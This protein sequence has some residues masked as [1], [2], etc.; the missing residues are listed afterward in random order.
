MSTPFT[1]QK[2]IEENISSIFNNK[3][4]IAAVAE[5]SFNNYKSKYREKETNQ[6]NLH[7]F[8]VGHTF[9]NIDTK[10]IFDYQLNEDESDTIPTKYLSLQQSHFQFGIKSILKKDKNGNEK[11]EK[12]ENL[13]DLMN[14]IRNIN[15]HYIHD[16]AFL[17]INQIDEKIIQFLKE[18]FEVALIQ[19]L[20]AKK[21]D[22][23]KNKLKKDFLSNE[24]KDN[25]LS[26]IIDDKDKELITFM[27][28]IF[29]QTLYRK[30]EKDWGAKQNEYR[31]KK[32]FLNQYLTSK[33]DWIDWILFNEVEEDMIWSLNRNE[34]GSEDNHIHEV[35]NI[36]KGKYLSFEGCLFL[37]SMFLYANEANY[38]IPKLKGFNKNGTPQDASKLEVFR[39][40]AK[41]FK[42]QDIDGEHNSLVK[43]RDLVQYL[44]KFPVK[45]NAVLHTDVYY[46]EDLK[47]NIIE[48]EIK[49]Y[50][51]EDISEEFMIYAKHIL[52]GNQN[53]D[54]TIET[55][56]AIISKENQKKYHLVLTQNP[57]YTNNLSS[58][59]E[60]E[61]ELWKLVKKNNQTAEET[62]KIKQYQKSLE[63][64][65]TNNQRLEEKGKHLINENTE[66]LKKRI[67][68]KL[69]YISN[70]R[71]ND[72]FI[73][74]AM[75]YL[76]EVKYF[77]KDAQ[78]KMYQYYYSEEEQISLHK[79]K[80]NQDK[81]VYDKIHFHN[82][83]QTHF[84]TYKKHLE[85]YPDWETPFV[86]QNNAVFVKTS[87][88]YFEKDAAFCLQR[89]LLNYFLEDAL[90][91]DQPENKGKKILEE[92]HQIKSE[93]YN[94]GVEI[95]SDTDKNKSFDKSK[96]QKL[97]PKRL[98]HQY[99]PAKKQSSENENTFQK[100]L[101][102]A[103]KAEE[104][105]KEKLEN[106]K[107][108]NNEDYF[109]KKNKGKQFKLR[110]IFK[111]WQLMYFREKYNQLKEGEAA[112]EKLNGITKK[113][114]HEYGHH[115]I[116]NITRDEYNTFCK[117]MFAL[118]EIP[119]Y[120]S[121]LEILLKSKHF[122]DN[123][124]FEMLFEKASTLDQ[125]YYHT[126][127]NFENWLKAN[128]PKNNS[129]RFQLE[130]YKNWMEKG[131]AFI[132]LSHFIDF[133]E[134]KD[135]I[136]KRN[137]KIRRPCLRNAQ[138]L[139]E[140]YYE[141]NQENSTFQSLEKPKQNEIKNFHAK[142]FKNRLEDC[143][144]YEIALRYMQPN[145][146][147]R[148]NSRNHLSQLLIQDLHIEINN[149]HWMDRNNQLKKGK[150]SVIVPFKDLEKFAQLQ[151]FDEQQ[152][153]Y[154][155]LK[156]LPVYLQKIEN[157]KEQVHQLKD[158][159]QQYRNDR[160]ITLAHICTINNHLITQQGRFTN[161]IMAME[162]Y[163][164]WKHQ[165]TIAQSVSAKPQNRIVMYD[166]PTLKDY[167]DKK[168]QS[169][170]TAFHI[171]LPMEET[172]Q[173]SFSKKEKDFVR[174][175]VKKNGYKT[176]QNCPKM[177]Q[178]TL[179]VFM[180]QMHD[181]VKM[182]F[183]EKDTEEQKKKKREKAENDFFEKLTK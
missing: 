119:Q 45:W 174:T 3:G 114:E 115:K 89:D 169:R 65:N 83:K 93:G 145:K 135:M 14:N 153:N 55:K 69:L 177:L 22:E 143:L 92:Y 101:D 176:L 27:K 85:K 90:Y 62:S 138:Y 49:K 48:I 73:D 156:N 161:C 4:I 120:K 98:L 37:M 30:Q 82:G 72:R 50:Y 105:Y 165:F 125:F 74:F 1:N 13:Y 86:V 57:E 134:S 58:I 175:E 113:N 124:E 51:G 103:L 102:Q 17:E 131:N 87:G 179:K 56:F 11:T 182:K 20:F 122:F 60:I 104:L 142:L 108:D 137:G 77:G 34:D 130:N 99:I 111:A 170:N 28:E 63:K 2:K 21:R 41:K 127:V 33:K 183:H 15:A 8:A 167:F 59:S 64:L 16:F 154:S 158:T 9:K 151:Y 140:T 152:K 149:A 180:N 24:E 155:I 66:K 107:T 168:D 67:A 76:A 181:D 53:I 146:K 171:N 26:E 100:Y 136:K 18:S 25:I 38:L 29:Y 148:E 147:L 40:F 43:F 35:L 39:F 112:F 95:L 123:K 80:Q 109:L 71:N 164:I 128:S 32:E 139:Y 126:K 118:D 19:G 84:C 116:Q 117:W 121:S 42:S 81:K 46:M 162:E 23:K 54:K 31:Q 172:Y 12:K 94:E 78:F 97:F 150:Y 166:I 133:A 173:S 132:N 36:P 75:R 160:S 91:S 52:W 141:V 47:N 157:N 5:K 106:A 79:I 110:F 10:K 68:E 44:G 96:L 6:S 7:Y 159:V 61:K 163:F 129:T 88:V 144:L 70:G 178:K